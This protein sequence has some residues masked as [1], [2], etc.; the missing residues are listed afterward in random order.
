VAKPKILLTAG[1]TGGHIFPAL[2]LGEVLREDAGCDVLFAGGQL[3]QNP[4]FEQNAYPYQDVLAGKMTPN[5][6]EWMKMGLGLIQSIQLIK[7]FDPDLVLGFG[8]YYTVPLLAAA[9]ILRKPLFLHESNSIPGRVNRYF[10][11]YAEMTWVHFPSTIS[12]LKGPAETAKMPLRPLFRKGILSKEKARE[13]WGLE[14][15]LPTLLAFG[16]SQGAQGVNTLFVS[17]ACN[18][19]KGVRFQVI[20][21]TGSANDTTILEA[22]RQAG[23][24]A[25][26][27]PFEKRMDMAWA[28]ADLA[29]TRSGAA[30]FAE[31]VEY[32]VPGIFIPYPHSTDGHQR[33]NA[34]YADLNGL[35]IKRDQANLSPE[36]LAQ[37][38]LRLL[39]E[40]KEFDENF[41][42]YKANFCQESLED[43]V[44]KRIKSGR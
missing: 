40:K 2:A 5:P 33:K 25:Y 22:Y 4:Y 29:V 13:G 6:F 19:L 14:P 17:A 7:K 43:K 12:L 35:G 44:M 8:S 34:A 16:G 26:V 39:A 37:D 31:Q 30:S 23:I 15:N 3:S 10:S 20:H 21:F 36:T 32:E 1:G 24:P 38:I 18:H 42:K 41:Q 28:A 27:R 9:K 11:P